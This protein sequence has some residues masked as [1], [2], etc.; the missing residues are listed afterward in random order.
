MRRRCLSLG[1]RSMAKRNCIVRKLPSVETLGCTTVICSDKTGTLTTNEMCVVSV[2]TFREDG[3]CE[4]FGVSGISYSPYGHLEGKKSVK[5]SDTSL[6][7]IA[8]ICAMCNEASIHYDAKQKR[9]QAVGEPTEAALKVLVEKLGMPGDEDNVVTGVRCNDQESKHTNATP[10]DATHLVD[11][12]WKKLYR[13]TG[14]LEFSRARKSMS[15]LCTRQVGE[16]R[17]R[18]A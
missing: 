10:A 16:A 15:V 4:E 18:E 1:T 13:V 14:L 17:A 7:E 11:D 6:A 12:A 9:F 8:R 5:E 3:S 2:A